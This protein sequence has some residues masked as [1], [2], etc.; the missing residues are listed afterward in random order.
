MSKPKH[1]PC[2]GPGYELVFCKTIRL[3]NGRVLHAESYGRKA[4]AFWVKAKR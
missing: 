1:G 2:P 3:K 4:W